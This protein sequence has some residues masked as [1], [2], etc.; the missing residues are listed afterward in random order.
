MRK[1]NL[2]ELSV[3]SFETNAQP[4]SRGTVK[5]H[6][7]TEPFVC[8]ESDLVSCGGSCGFTNCGDRTCAPGCTADVSCNGTCNCATYDFT[9][10][11]TGP[12]PE[13]TCC[14]QTC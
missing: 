1:L 4:A 8:G 14:Q 5:G 3:D 6:E 10:E 13:G 12:N 9:C 2:D 11:Y 7:W